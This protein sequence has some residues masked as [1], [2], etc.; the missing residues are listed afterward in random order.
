M[1]REGLQMAIM[2][3]NRNTAANYWEMQF[4]I[5]NPNSRTYGSTAAQQAYEAAMRQQ[6]MSNP[7]KALR[8]HDKEQGYTGTNTGSNAESGSGG[9]SGGEINQDI[10]NQMAPGPEYDA[11]YAA[12]LERQNSFAEQIS[13]IEEAQREAEAARLESYNLGKS[14]LN[15]TSDEALRQTFVQKRM[16]ER[17]LPQQLAL[18]GSNGGMTESSVLGM[19]ADYGENRTAIENERQRGLA[20]LAAQYQ[21]GAAA[22]S[23]NWEMAIANLRAQQ[24]EADLSYMIW[25]AE[26][27]AN[28]AAKISNTSSKTSKPVLSL[29]QAEEAYKNGNQSENVLSAL[30][31]Y[32][33]ANSPY[34]TANRAATAPTASTDRND[35]INQA[36][37]SYKSS[38]QSLQD[39]LS[40]SDVR[41][42]LQRSGVLNWF[43]NYLAANARK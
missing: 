2:P 6:Q 25:A 15:K 27:A 4:G 34:D 19:N 24:S 40:R 5:A 41:V 31:Y 26:Q 3:N 42:A 21:S 30:Q 23:M 37:K 17:D 11:A 1:K 36:L 16:A 32:Y 38:G 22:D 9:W 39:W 12:W 20:D 8:D 10:L 13:A 35:S 18:Q 28:N 29:A 14:S 43:E 33:G 7:M